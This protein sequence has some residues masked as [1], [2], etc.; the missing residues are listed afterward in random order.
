[1]SPLLPV[2]EHQVSVHAAAPQY[3]HERGHAQLFPVDEEHVQSLG[4]VCGRGQR[5]SI[6]WEQTDPVQMA[7]KTPPDPRQ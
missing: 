6:R 1:M 4:H 2:H 3:T 5:K 7:P